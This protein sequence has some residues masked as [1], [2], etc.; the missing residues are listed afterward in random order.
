MTKVT[1]DMK[2]YVIIKKKHGWFHKEQVQIIGVV[3][4]VSQDYAQTS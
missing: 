2:P 4:W 3:L 1:S